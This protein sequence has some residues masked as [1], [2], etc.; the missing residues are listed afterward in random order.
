MQLTLPL[1]L[2][3][4]VGRR[5]AL[6][7][8]LSALLPVAVLAV[9]GYRQVRAELQELA[10]AELG[11]TARDVGQGLLDQLKGAENTLLDESASFADTPADRL[12]ES[13]ARRT[14]RATFSAL[15]LV[16]GATVRALWGQAPRNITLSSDDLDWL[17]RGRRLLRLDGDPLRAWLVGTAGRTRLVW[18]AVDTGFLFRGLTER[19][20]SAAGG[21]FTLCIRAVHRDAPLFCQGTFDAERELSASWDLFLASQFHAP[22]LRIRVWQSL[23][24]VYRP[25]ERFRRTFALSIITVLALVVLLSSVQVRRSLQPLTE[26]GA[27]TRRL[28][29]RDFSGTVAVSSGDEFEDLADSFNHM[30]AE[31]DR[32]FRTLTAVNAIDQVALT[33]RNAADVAATAAVRLRDVLACDAVDVYIAGGRPDDPWRCVGASTGDARDGD[34]IRPAAPDLQALRTGGD[35]WLHA[36]GRDLAWLPTHHG[37]AALLPLISHGE[38]VGLV[39]ARGDAEWADERLR[40]ARHLGDQLTLGL[41]NAGL[42]DRLN[43]LSYGALFALARTVDANSP[44]TAGHS[45]RV[46]ALSLCIGEHLGLGTAALDTIHRGGLLH[47]IGKV[48]IHIEV[49]DLDGPLSAAERATIQTHPALG[50]KILAPIAAFDDAIPIVLHHHEKFDGRGYPDGL[51]GESIPYLARL[52]AVADVYDALVSNRPYRPGWEHAAV[53][54][55]MRVEAGVHFDPEI[56][57]AFLVVMDHFGDQARFRPMPQPT[58]RPA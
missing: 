15:A 28:A 3:T 5:M 30:T 1:T 57:E 17:R 45:E 43:D 37:H 9:E 11:Q 24:D 56:V 2:Q 12:T 21:G 49:L 20:R 16:D 29:Q 46:T 13:G 26:L 47:D 18:A 23:A 44:W 33:A 48:G 58:G 22:P 25:E 27:A 35:G 41:R 8:V 40:A 52:V 34:P 19:S 14:A 55:H 39:V 10:T 36:R 51:R 54:A 6:M 42:I 4:R 38:Q 7:F 31:I 50:A 53:L 32:Q